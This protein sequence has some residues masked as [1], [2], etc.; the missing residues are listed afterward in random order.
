LTY[1]IPEDYFDSV[2]AIDITNPNALFSLSYYLYVIKI[3]ADMPELEKYRNSLMDSL[4]VKSLDELK[5]TKPY[6][7]YQVKLFKDVSE[8]ADELL[9][10]ELFRP[11][12]TNYFFLRINIISGA[13][14]REN[15]LYYLE[16]KLSGTVYLPFILNNYENLSSHLTKGKAAPDFYLLSDQQN[17]FL[18]LVDFNGKALLLNFWFPGCKPCILEI[19]H[20]KELMKKYGDKGFTIINICMEAT[21]KQWQTALKNYN[22][23]GVN[24]VTQGNWERKLKEAYGVGGFPHYVLIDQAGKIVENQTH[25]PS[26]PRLAEL[27]EATLS[28]Q[29]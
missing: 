12:L 2:N 4:G 10:D 8:K 17:R 11:F 27:I 7:A 21:V 13:S 9:S 15:L 5:G 6:E 16:T 22:L 28:N 24:V 19:P 23:A 25:K 3:V 1:T 29:R 18:A 14:D 20:E 26:D